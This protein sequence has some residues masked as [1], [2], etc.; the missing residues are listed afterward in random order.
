MLAQS[1]VLTS[2]YAGLISLAHAGFYGIGAYISAILSIK[3]G[4]SFLISLPV[5]MLSTGFIAVII[6]TIAL[7]AVDD[8]FI[9]ITLGIQVI[10]YSI[11][12]NW[13]TITNGSLGLSGIPSISIAG[14]SFN[15][16]V[17]ILLL[18]LF[19]TAIVFCVLRNITK[20]PFGR[21]LLSLSQD[22]IFTKSLGKNVYSAKVISFAIGGMLSA[23]PG[24]LY[25][26]YISYIDPSSFTI[27]ESI[28]ILSIVIIGGNKSLWKVTLA[29][30]FL[31]IFP[32]LLRFIGMPSSLAANIKQ[33][34][35][36]FAIVLIMFKNTHSKLSFLIHHNISNPILNISHQMVLR[37][38]WCRDRCFQNNEKNT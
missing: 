33:I 34:L 6:S 10:A 29:T 26:H 27:T 5:A 35:Y 4:V 24:A 15:G 36:G 25:A 2:G 16:K 14:I 23:I 30:A 28:F 21:I 20:S 22:E 38:F 31:I 17:S 9:I 13:M 32:E 1:L 19:L 12:N 3:Y 18:S 37:Q 8:Y 11:M 7:R